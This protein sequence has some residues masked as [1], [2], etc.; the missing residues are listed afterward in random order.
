MSRVSF[1]KWGLKAVGGLA[2]NVALLTVWVDV[3]GLNEVLAI[4]PNFV[5][6]STLGYTITNRWIWPDG[7]SPTSPR[8]HARQ[9]LGMQAANF[10]GKAANFAIYILLLAWVPYQVAWVLGAVLT[11]TVTFLLNQWWWDG[12]RNSESIA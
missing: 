7:V 5:I 1:I 9:Y 8:G 3:V 10:A 4:V 2:L 12:R 11:F 6:I